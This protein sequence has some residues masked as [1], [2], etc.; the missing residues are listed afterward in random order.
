Y[1][2]FIRV[3][4]VLSDFYTFLEIAIGHVY[5]FDTTFVPDLVVDCGGN[6]GMFSLAT[7]AIYPSSKIVIC[8]PVP[9]NLEQI[10]RHIQFND[11]AAEVLPVCVGGS[12]RVI[13]FFIREAIS[14]SF[15]PTKPYTDKL[16]VEVWTLGDVLGGRNAQRILIKLDIEGME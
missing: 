8:E 7:S 13:P 15:D 3:D 14:S 9:R 6:I 16:E 12:R 5:K 2:V 4:D 10:K 11:V 1:I